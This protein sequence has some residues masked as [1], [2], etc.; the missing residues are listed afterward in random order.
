[1]VTGAFGFVG[2]AVVRRL[3]AA[4]HSVV[5]LTQRAEGTPLPP[6]AAAKVVRGDVRSFDLMAQ[7]AES[8]DGVC[9]LA[10]LTQVRESFS[11][12]EEYFSVNAAGT[13]VVVSALLCAAAQGRSIRLIQAST[14]AVYGHT[15]TSL[16]AESFPAAPASPYGASKLAAEGMALSAAASGGLGV[17][18]LRAF[19]VAGAVDGRGDGDLSRLIPKAVAVARGLA[20]VFE[21]N[22]DGAAVRDYVHVDDVA[23]AFVLALEQS[24]A[25]RGAVYNVGATAA[26]VASVLEAVSRAASRP[27]PVNHLP[28]KQEVVS[29]LA[30]TAR[31]RAELGWAPERSALDRIVADAWA[32]EQSRYIPA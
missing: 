3:A 31:I 32:A 7:L 10:G 4:G 26:S 23:R 21:I 18:V 15:P 22:G 27:L 25:G 13:G 16:I 14:A 24:S 17:A 11:R 30:D 28:P 12:P 19:N 29:V 1:L 6:T 9:H 5:A 2:T 20:P 8:V